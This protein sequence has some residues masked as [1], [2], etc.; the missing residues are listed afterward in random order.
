MRGRRGSSVE[1]GEAGVARRR[2][3]VRRDWRGPL[4]EGGSGGGAA[5]RQ[6]EGRRGWPA[7]GGRERWRHGSSVEGEMGQPA[8]GGRGGRGGLLG[9]RRAWLDDDRREG[10]GAREM[11]GRGKDDSSDYRARWVSIEGEGVRVR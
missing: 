10:A 6:R 4:V 9:G 1:G 8:G 2:R 3:E 11:K 7:S 5:C